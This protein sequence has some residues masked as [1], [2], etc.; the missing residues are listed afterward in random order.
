M[1]SFIFKFIE[2]ILV[3]VYKKFC[4]SSSS[5]TFFLLFNTKIFLGSPHYFIMCVTHI[6][7]IITGTIVS[8]RDQWNILNTQTQTRKHFTTKKER[9]RKNSTTSMLF[10]VFNSLSD[11]DSSTLWNWLL[12]KDKRPYHK[13][14]QQQQHQQTQHRAP[15]HHVK[16]TWQNMCAYI[17]T[18]WDWC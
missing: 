6:M 9:E 12:T 7:R 5:S 3:C 10:L 14:T 18:H 8:M 15:V 13:K 1:Q 11:F 16:C 4:Y 17:Y 2:T